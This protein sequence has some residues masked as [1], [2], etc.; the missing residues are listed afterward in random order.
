MEGA[1][2]SPNQNGLIELNE[3]CDLD[4]LASINFIH[5]GSEAVTDV[6]AGTSDNV[7]DQINAMH[8]SQADKNEIKAALKEE[9]AKFGA[10]DYV[11]TSFGMANAS[12]VSGVTKI[13]LNGQAI[14]NKVDVGASYA[15]RTGEAVQQIKST[16]KNM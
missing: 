7:N 4:N 8:G 14:Q 9:V 13:A 10:G 12:T 2:Y 1:V 5:V 15:K 3:K 6:T 16:Y 11:M